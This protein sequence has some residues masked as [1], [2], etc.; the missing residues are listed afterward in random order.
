MTEEGGC[1]EEERRDQSRVDIKAKNTL[2]VTISLTC[3]KTEA[4]F[5]RMLIHTTSWAVFKG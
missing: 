5:D 1:W 3:S 4:S 2:S